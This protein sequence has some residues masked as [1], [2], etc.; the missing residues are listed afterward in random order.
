MKV[1]GPPCLCR[2]YYWIKKGC[3]GNTY[4]K[5][6][7]FSKQ[8]YRGDFAIIRLVNLDQEVPVDFHCLI[9][10]PKEVE[11]SLTS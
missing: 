2:T 7:G 3:Q 5:K 8:V 9:N 4:I 11:S 10:S 1:K 6:G